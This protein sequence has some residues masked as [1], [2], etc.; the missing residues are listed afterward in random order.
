MVLSSAVWDE[1]M[2][3]NSRMAIYIVLA[4][5]MGYMIVSTVPTTLTPPESDALRAGTKDEPIMSA[6]PERE[7]FES[8]LQSKN[9]TTMGINTFQIGIWVLDLLIALG[10]YF[11]AKRWLA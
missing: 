4:I 7:V 1:K 3:M 9:A 5:A 2:N 10:A 11:L 8:E 6:Q